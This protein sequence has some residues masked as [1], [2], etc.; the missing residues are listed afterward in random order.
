MVREIQC[1][2]QRNESL[3]EEKGSLVEKNHWI[4]RIM[5]SLADDGHETEI[6][7][8]LK[9]GESHKTIAEWLGRPLQNLEDLSPA[10]EIEL[11][12]AIE[13]YHQNLVKKQD[14]R[15]WTN[16][17]QDVPMIE[18]LVALYFTWIHPAH[19]LFNEDLFMTSFRGCSDTYCSMSLV[20]A[21]CAVSCSFLY[22]KSDQDPDPQ[23]NI[24]S[25]RSK[26]LSE[27]FS[28][29]KEA[30][31][32][33]MTVIQT[34]AVVF[35]A[36]L[37]SCNAPAATFHLRLAAESLTAKQHG[38]QT[39]DSEEITARGIL[40]LHTWVWFHSLGPANM[41]TSVAPGQD[42]CIRNRPLRFLYSLR[43]SRRFR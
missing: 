36:E 8:R 34:Y 4:E 29:Q 19:M 11:V 27:V 22:R 26:F 18:H 24:D 7:R 40:T 37:G 3:E 15:Y 23:D 25:L 39:G 5:G 14:P 35:L 38:E 12:Q 16:A 21:I 28:H 41:L 32:S 9:R 13:R 10:S 30:D 43:L 6:V 20:N 2:Q 33:K 31:Y 42:S 17:T 1:L